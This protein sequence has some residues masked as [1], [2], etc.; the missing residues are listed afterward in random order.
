MSSC[1]AVVEL[2]T[3]VAGNVG[4]CKAMV[5]VSTAEVG[6]CIAIVELV[7]VMAAE[8]GSCIAIVTC[9]DS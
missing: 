6:G 4:S 3:V 5:N 2:V 1:I 8:G 9:V 7:T